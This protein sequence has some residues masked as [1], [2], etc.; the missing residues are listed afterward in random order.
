M[1]RIIAAYGKV[2]N[3]LELHETGFPEAEYVQKCISK[4]IPISGMDGVGEGKDSSGSELLINEIDH[5]LPTMGH[6][7]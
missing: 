7:A 3:N 2:R 5:L 1:S 6:H 4:G